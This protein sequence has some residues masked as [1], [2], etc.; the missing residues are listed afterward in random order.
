MY[1]I[2]D[3]NNQNFVILGPIAWKPKYISNILSDE[4]DEEITVTAADETRVPFDVIPGVTIRKC[5]AFYEDI[6]PKIERH[7]GPF[8]VYDDSNSEIQ[9]VATWERRDRPINMVKSEL[10]AHVADLRW[11]KENKGITLNIQGTDVW[12]DT[13]RG[14][15]DIFIQ[16]YMIMGENDTINWKFPTDVWLSLNKTELGLIVSSGAAY[17]QSCFDWESTQSSIIEACTTLEELNLLI[18]EEVNG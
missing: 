10:K 1:V 13:S 14:N 12:C 15:R 7:E 5:S 11:Q 16:K 9:A 3:H 4:F 18:F 6:N 8:W 2:T 17:I